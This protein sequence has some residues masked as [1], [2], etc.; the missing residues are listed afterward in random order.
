M[1]G[2]SGAL[3]GV[4]RAGAVD[5]L[6][7]PLFI[8]AIIAATLVVFAEVGLSFFVINASVIPPGAGV[9]QELGVPAGVQAVNAAS[10][11]DP[12]GSGIASLALI[13]GL[14]LFTVGMLG[15]SLILPLRI[16]GRIQGLVTLIV[17][18]LWIIM[19]F[20]LVIAALVKLFLMIG[21][22]VAAPFGTAVY[23]AIWG[24]FPTGTAA[25]VLGAVL[26]LKIVFGVLLVLAQPRFLRVTGLVVLVLLSVVLQLVLG[27]IHGFLPGVVVAIGDQ[28]WAIVTGMVALVWA[29]IMLIGSIPGIINAIRASGSATD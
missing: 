28:F 13:D 27:F 12:P 23:V 29:L 5:G 10:G 6:R 24:A 25:A 22:F 19:C 1:A 14:L 17:T 7:R 18:F 15:L 11:Q 26:F 21:L 16:Y 8:A 20:L 2:V 9:A 4:A 3:P